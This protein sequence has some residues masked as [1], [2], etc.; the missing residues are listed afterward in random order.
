MFKKLASKCVAFAIQK[1]KQS[2]FVQS[3]FE[4][5]LHIESLSVC[6]TFTDSFGK[7]HDLYAE[8]RTIIKPGWE[9]IFS[10]QNSAHSKDY[11][12]E[13][14]TQGKIAVDKILPL[15]QSLG[16]DI[17][18]SR[19]L[20]IG[21]HSGAV[22][23]AFAEKGA[24][25]VVG[26]EFSGYKVA[27]VKN[28]DL[29]EPVLQ[30]V[31][32][33]LVELRNKVAAHFTAK[34]AVS[35]VDDDICNSTLDKESFDIIVSWDVLEHLHNTQEACNAIAGLL[36]EDGIAIFDYNPFFG[37][38]G[39]HSYCTLDFLW[40]HVRLHA[41]DFETYISE[42]RPQEKEMA[43]SFYHRGINRLTIADITEQISTAGLELVSIIP[44][45]KE[46]HIR[47]LTAD[48]VAEAQRNYPRLQITD[49]VAPRVV[50][51]VRKKF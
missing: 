19:I 44:F 11:V 15:L 23:Y 36:K 49:L 1:A 33:H 18:Q 32:E 31:H 30:E 37:L 38:N 7:K 8:L 25:S 47:M 17:S 13:R 51:V 40:G 43:L 28:T 20:E 2:S 42:I 12:Q 21:C 14:I 45:V 35:F 50:L 34:S 24:R 6:N 9:H 46:Q 26:S 27:S 3:V 5:P 22:C 39:G 10:T 48:I 16:K 29:T 4:K 41:Q